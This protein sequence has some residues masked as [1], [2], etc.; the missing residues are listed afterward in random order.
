MGALDPKSK[1]ECDRRI[2]DLEK[3]VA[4][5]KQSY[6]NMKARPLNYSRESVAAQKAEIEGLKG[7]IKS[8]KALRK[9][10]K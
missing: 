8:L 6:E 1:A 7:Q 5:R 3:T 4:Y 10:L 2:A 9:T